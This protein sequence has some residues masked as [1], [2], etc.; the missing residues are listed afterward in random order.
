MNRNPQIL[1]IDLGS[2]Y[3]E[4]IRRSLRYLGFHSIILPPAKSLKWAKDNKPKSII[5]SGGSA[6]VYEKS[7]PKIPEEILNLGVPVL[8]ICYGMQWLAYINDKKAVHKVKE[9]KSY[10]P[11]EVSLRQ[12][13]LFVNL[14]GS[15]R[16]WSSHG[17]SVK[18]APTGFKVIAT[19]KSGKVIEAMENEKKKLYAVQFHPEVEQTEDENIIL[20][21]F[22]RNICR[23]NPDYL[24]KDAK[25]PKKAKKK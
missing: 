3:T 23:A 19:S 7:A 1:I 6:S 8:G 2:Q 15:I 12:S 11:V 5:L 25:K 22:V 21:N 18:K 9:G 17:D 16:A 14:S 13:K 20:N 4:V 10:G 24:R